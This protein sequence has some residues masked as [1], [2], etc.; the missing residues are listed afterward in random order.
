MWEQDSLV[1]FGRII[2]D[3]GTVYQI[4]DVVVDP[5]YQGNG[6]GKKI[7]NELVSYLE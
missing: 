6:L 4:V 2:G 3:K 7:M 5:A 1:G